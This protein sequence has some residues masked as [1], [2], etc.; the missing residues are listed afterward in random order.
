MLL[1]LVVRYEFWYIVQW[2]NRRLPFPLVRF[3]I[4]FQRNFA[5]CLSFIWYY[6]AIVFIMLLLDFPS[7]LCFVPW[8]RSQNAVR[9]FHIT[10]KL[11][12]SFYIG[13]FLKMLEDHQYSSI[14]KGGLFLRRSWI[15]WQILVT[16]PN[17]IIIQGEK[18][19]K[20][21]PYL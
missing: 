2:D 13:M 16:F 7:V 20:C 1:N 14:T 6:V 21:V 10:C 9:A 17:N 12:S 15:D 11:L 19:F 3:N 4:S 18:G 8:P 5:H